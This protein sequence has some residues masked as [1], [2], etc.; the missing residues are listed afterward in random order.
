MKVAHISIKKGRII[1][2]GPGLSSCSH[3]HGL[4]SSCSFT[5]AHGFPLSKENNN[6]SGLISHWGPDGSVGVVSYSSVSPLFAQRI[7]AVSRK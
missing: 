5:Q 7:P 1:D 4:F 3:T 6:L 2:S